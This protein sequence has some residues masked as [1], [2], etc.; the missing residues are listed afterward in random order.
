MRLDPN[1][2]GNLG[3][4][5]SQAGRRILDY[6]AIIIIAKEVKILVIERLSI[7]TS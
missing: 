1:R 7:N 5:L 2:E 6:K 3:G 4:L